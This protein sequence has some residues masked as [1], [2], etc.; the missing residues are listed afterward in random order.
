MV[1]DREIMEH[2]CY[3]LDDNEMMARIYPSLVESRDIDTRKEALNYIAIRGQT[4]GVKRVDR[5]NYA[6]NILQKDV[7]PHVG[8]TQGVPTATLP[9]R[10]SLPR[11]TLTPQGFCLTPRRAAGLD[12]K[13]AYFLGYTVHRLLQTAMGRREQDDRDHLAA[14]RYDMC[15]SLLGNLF[16]QLFRKVT[17]DVKKELQKAV[18]RNKDFSIYALKGNTITA[19]LKY[20]LATGNW[21]MQGE[22][23]LK[24]GVSQVLNRLTYASVSHGLQPQSRMDHPH[25]SC[26]LTRVRSRH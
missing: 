1:S 13:K 5:I 24:T 2:I 18:D 10:C 25:C 21:G 8:I 3:D 6:K 26:K 11:V 7:L 19:G 20:A 9:T 15:G 12:T 23:G 14:K 16:R 4:E 17:K 22:L